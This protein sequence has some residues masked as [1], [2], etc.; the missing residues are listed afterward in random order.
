MSTKKDL[1]LAEKARN[2][3][4]ALDDA[5][6]NIDFEYESDK[7][8]DQYNAYV[9]RFK[10]AKKVIQASNPDYKFIMLMHPR[11]FIDNLCVEADDPKIILKA[12]G[13][14]KVSGWVNT[15]KKI[16]DEFDDLE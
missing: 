3:L 13:R 5:G 12:I 7:I 11:E 4:K 6:C 9:K 1:E 16:R 8:D 14:R 10:K 15:P 2:Y